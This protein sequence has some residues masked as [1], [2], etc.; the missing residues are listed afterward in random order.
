M[1]NTENNLAEKAEQASFFHNILAKA[2]Y[3][4]K[5]YAVDLN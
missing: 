4:R 3:E 1:L 5:T 2:H